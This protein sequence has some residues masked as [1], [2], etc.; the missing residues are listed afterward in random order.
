[1]SDDTQ[2]V[3]A[4]E[5]EP[6]PATDAPSRTDGFVRGLSQ[7]IGGPLGRHAGS[8]AGNPARF[9]TPMR[10]VLAIT[11]GVLAL[12]WL[13]KEPCADGRWVNNNQYT[14]ACYTDVLA[15]YGAEGLDKR[16]IPYVEKRTDDPSD[17]LQYVEYPVLTGAMML[18]AAL[19]V[20]LVAAL[21]P[22]VPEFSLF[23]QV[24]VLLLTVL[25]VLAV[26]AVVR[27]R[28]HRPFDAAMLAAAPAMVFTAFVNWDMLAIALCTLALYAWAK[29][30]PAWA[31]VLLGLAAAAKFYPLFILGPL[32]LLCLRRRQIMPFLSTA[33][34]AVTAWVVV[35]L[36]VV[37][38]AGVPAWSQFYRFSSQRAVDWGT[39]WYVGANLTGPGSGP[40]SGLANDVSTLNLVTGALFALWCI[41]VAALIFTAPVPPRLT[42]LAFLV[43]AGFLL[44]GKVW[45][46]QYVLWLIPL[47]VLA[48][49]KWGAFLIWQLSE[50]GYFLAFYQT[51]IRAS[52]GK[53]AMPESLFVL[54]SVARWASVLLLC[55]LVVLEIYEPWRDAVRTSRH[56]DPDGGVL[57]DDPDAYDESLQPRPI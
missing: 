1:M 11:L 14:R 38:L 8:S 4:D 44:T 20:W 16:R 3:P 10:V 47:L 7:L 19:P 22:G 39:F 13:Q 42:Q 53:T 40:L 28:Q 12:S 54:A 25:A 48:R 32:F 17:P 30:H 56:P 18:I 51:L 15:L 31:G 57:N 33:G 36:P 45:S 49:P 5:L 23:Y 27:M 9:W 50:F 34:A 35:N 52:N 2:T 26:W 55:G 24:N 29:R 6:E 41:G 37:V 43:V 21:V 46:Q